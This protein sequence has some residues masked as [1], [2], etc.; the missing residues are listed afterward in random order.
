MGDRAVARP[1]H[2]EREVTPMSESIP[3]RA[4]R[5]ARDHNITRREAYRVALAESRMEREKERRL[6]PKEPSDV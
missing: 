2:P 1:F 3:E 5:I 4:D 6:T